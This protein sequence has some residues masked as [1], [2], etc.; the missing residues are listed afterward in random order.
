MVENG[1]R[2]HPF[3]PS[4]V[5]LVTGGFFLAVGVITRIRACF[6]VF[7]DRIEFLPVVWPGRR[8]RV[9]PLESIGSRSLYYRWVAEGEDF[10]RFVEWR[11]QR[12]LPSAR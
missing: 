7:E 12:E 4:G 6:E 3:I 5:L 11:D 8:R 9:A 2:G 10:K 1:I